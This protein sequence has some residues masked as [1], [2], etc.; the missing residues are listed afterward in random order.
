MNRI[1]REPPRNWGLFLCYKYDSYN[2]RH[3]S[4]A[5]EELK[6]NVGKTPLHSMLRLS[7]KEVIKIYAKLEWQEF[8]GEFK[9]AQSID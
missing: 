9:V 5:L 2:I 1:Q 7:P 6:W 3:K 4:Q 8:G